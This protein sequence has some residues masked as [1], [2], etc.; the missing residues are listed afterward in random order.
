M[1]IA[2][3][4]IP[5]PMHAV[6]KLKL[7]VPASRQEVFKAPEVHEP[8]TIVF[9]LLAES[10][11]RAPELVHIERSKASASCGRLADE[12]G[13]KAYVRLTTSCVEVKSMGIMTKAQLDHT[14]Q[15]R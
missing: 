1:T 13:V 7:A 10:L 8:F 15:C 4:L 12:L 9:D 3:V 6:G 14:I 11:D 5:S 2:G